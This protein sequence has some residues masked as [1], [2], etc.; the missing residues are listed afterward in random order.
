M[1][2]PHWRELQW[3]EFGEVIP[4]NVTVAQAKGW[5]QL[6]DSIVSY[7]ATPKTEAARNRP[8]EFSDNSEYHF[9]TRPATKDR[10]LPNIETIP[11][12]IPL[13]LPPIVYVASFHSFS[14]G[15]HIFLDRSTKEVNT[16]AEGSKGR[17]N[18]TKRVLARIVKHHN[19]AGTPLHR[20]SRL[21][22][23]EEDNIN[24]AKDD[25]RF[26]YVNWAALED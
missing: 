19:S 2:A 11:D 17:D 3:E 9:S 8:H 10:Y 20:N 4:G 26:R 25:K 16:R 21:P 13:G 14:T 7:A 18:R 1:P 15:N 6:L 5:Q 22:V 24:G 23:R 12:Y